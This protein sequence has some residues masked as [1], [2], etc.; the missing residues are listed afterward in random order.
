[1][2]IG[3]HQ[4]G[5]AFQ[6]QAVLV[7]EVGIV[8]AD[9]DV[10]FGQPVFVKLRHRAGNGA[11]VFFEQ[12]GAEGHAGLTGLWYLKGWQG[13]ARRQGRAGFPPVKSGL[14]RQCKAGAANLV[15]AR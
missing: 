7:V 10:A 15:E 8:D 4:A 1:M 13:P 14:A 9:G 3:A 11:V 6:N 5:Q 2:G 12:D